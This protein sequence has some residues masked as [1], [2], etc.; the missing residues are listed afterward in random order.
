MKG[1]TR[2]E[3]K[4]ELNKYLQSQLILILFKNVGGGKWRTLH[5]SQS[6][7][8]LHVKRFLSSF[9]PFASAKAK[10]VIGIKLTSS[11]FT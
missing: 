3:K 11:Y 6:F 4:V 8:S 10:E 7:S 2:A 1:K 9:F 5:I